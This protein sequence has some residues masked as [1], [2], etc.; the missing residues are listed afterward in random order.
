[1]TVLADALPI[2]IAAVDREGTQT[3]VNEAFAR[4][5]GWP[6]E[7]LVGARPP[8]VYWP[9]DQLAT[10]QRAF[11]S[12]LR[13]DPAPD[14]F[15]LVFGRRDGSVLDVLVHL[16][17]IGGDMS[18]ARGWVAAVIDISTQSALQR[19]LASNEAALRDAYAAERLAREDAEDIARR[20]RALQRA[21]S[22]LT[23]L[24]TPDQ[25]A[26]VVMHEAVPA[27]GGSRGGVALIS[28]DGR[29]LKVVSM[30]GYSD[31]T[32]D[33]YATIPMDAK[34]PLADVVRENRSLFLPDLASRA[35]RYPHLAELLREN[36]AGAMA[37]IPLM[38][39]ERSIG[40]LGINWPDDH[41]FDEQEIGFLEALAHQCAQA[42][43]RARLYQEERQARLEAEEANRAKSDF[44]A[45][46]SHEL[47]TPLNGIAGYLD[48]LELGVRGPVTDEQKADLIRIRANQQ[49]LASLIEDVLSFARIEAGR[50]EVDHHSVSMDE[51]LRSLSPLVRPFMDEK[52]VQYEY[53]PCPS[54][55]AASGDAE[56]IVQI[57][58]NLLTNAAKATDPG[59][60]VT[61]ACARE[62]DMI[63]VKVHDTGSG[64]PAEKLN[65]IFSPFTQLGRSLK[66]PRA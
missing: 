16:G 63:V 21:T 57:C 28:E 11:E 64:I 66:A 20:I 35:A 4:M 14:G 42:L 17:A 12:T 49:H 37:A 61:L 65:S 9:P 7:E 38:V 48:L 36:G 18:G 55:L 58:V 15:Q 13:G 56:R 8:F 33:S 30:K 19:Q 51:T 59:G 1:V 34:F 3:Y 40:A 46:M 39:D 47:R 54:H 10:I 62:D 26:E 23:G 5:T 24:L 43:E 44:L 52:G 2:G 31:G 60:R 25:V 29:E 27:V 53:V 45:A 6:R 50:L 32:R 22:R 41:S